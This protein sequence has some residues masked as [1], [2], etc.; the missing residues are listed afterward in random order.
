MLSCL[1]AG[2]A[3]RSFK[4]E[5][6]PSVPTHV[7]AH[8]QTLFFS[9]GP[10]VPAKLHSPMHMVFMC[11]ALGFSFLLNFSVCNSDKMTAFLLFHSGFFANHK[12]ECNLFHNLFQFCLRSATLP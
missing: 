8:T 1:K 4:A 7:R 3:Q 6:T 10:A 2:R 5:Q 9:F 11:H 12:S